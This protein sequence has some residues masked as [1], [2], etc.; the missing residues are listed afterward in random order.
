MMKTFL[1]AWLII[2]SFAG[3]ASAQRNLITP[4][5][6]TN[7]HKVDDHLYR[8]AQPDGPGIQTLQKLGVR[9][10][11]NLRL[12]KES[13]SGEDAAA[14]AAGITC[15]NIPMKGLGRPVDKDID[16]ALAIIA[17]SPGPVYVHCA[18]GCDRTGTV[19]ACYRIKHD[20]WTSQ[21][22]LAEAKEL[23]MSALELGMKSGVADFERR[24]KTK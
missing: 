15:T 11:I 18:H 23:G 2:I 10:I 9:T 4:E 19:I 8:G 16:L 14:R 13:W 17:A 1:L 20:G 12:A 3:S 24:K 7:F 22:A 6:I 21:K 5:G